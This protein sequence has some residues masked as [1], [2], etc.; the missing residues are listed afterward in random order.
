MKKL[1]LLLTLCF[2]FS[3]CVTYHW[4]IGQTSEAFFEM[5]KHHT[6]QFDIVKS[7]TDMTIYRVGAGENVLFFYFKYNSLIEV[8]KGVPSPNFIIENR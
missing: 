2:L 7:S 3:S 6:R 1:L 8:D 5:N 4:Q